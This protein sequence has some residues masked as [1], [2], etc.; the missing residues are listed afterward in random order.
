[1]V[2]QGERFVEDKRQRYLEE[3][4]V[5]VEKSDIVVVVA[6]APHLLE[7]DVETAVGM[8]V[9]VVVVVVAVVVGTVGV[10]K[11]RSV[12]MEEVLPRPSL[13]RRRDHVGDSVDVDDCR[14]YLDHSQ[15]S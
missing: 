1:V 5:G 4:L 9:A 10:T 6:V 14:W 7:A 15:E 13:K 3:L 12:N 2:A 8:V 11:G